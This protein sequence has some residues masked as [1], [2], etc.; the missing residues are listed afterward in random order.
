MGKYQAASAWG[1][2]FGPLGSGLMY[3]KISMVAPFASA[4]ALMLPAIILVALYRLRPEQPGSD[5]I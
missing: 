1:R 3:S 4:A 5:A 2:F